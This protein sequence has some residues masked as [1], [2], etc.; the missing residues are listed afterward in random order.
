MRDEATATTLVRFR[1]CPSITQ[2]SL[3]HHVI[4]GNSSN[5]SRVERA[6]DQDHALHCLLVELLHLD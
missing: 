6:V 2:S 1:C 4:G 3:R 5:T